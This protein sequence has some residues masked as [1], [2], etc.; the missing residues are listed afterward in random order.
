MGRNSAYLTNSSL[1]E[2]SIDECLLQMDI[3][4][5]E[6]DSVPNNIIIY[7]LGCFKLTYCLL[8]IDSVLLEY[9]NMFTRLCQET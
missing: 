2:V 3:I 1:L 7:F 8:G 5:D 9:V 6:F 4:N